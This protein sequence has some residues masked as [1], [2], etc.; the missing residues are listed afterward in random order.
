MTGHLSFPKTKAGDTPASLSSWFIHDIL[1]DK[2]NYQGLIITDDLMMNGAANFAGS[3]SRA[4]KQ[5]LIAG[6]DIIMLSKT[7]S[8][9]DQVWTYLLAAM[10]DEPDFRTRVRDAA[11][12]ILETKFEY[13]RGEKKV[14]YIPDLKKVEEG[15]PDPEGAAFFLDLAARSVTIIKGEEN[16]FPLDKE[17]A[18][19]VLLAG[20]YQDFFTA[21]K[22][23]YPDAISYWYSSRSSSELLS[24]ARN[25]DTIIFC[26]SDQEGLDVL[27]RLRSLGKKI[28][29]FSVLSPVYLDE[30][31]WAD[32]AVAVYSYA[33]ESFIAGFSAMLGRIN[34]GGQLPFPLNEPRWA[35]PGN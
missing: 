29:I 11:R 19:K 27:R 31:S 7:P 5:A 12:R 26:L 6:N 13:L 9:N 23:A 15:L 8:L 2:I 22:K 35:P 18:G 30:A 28:I 3:L 32:G 24:Y 33:N 1:R 21:G 14:A 16:I 10:K 34:A 20:Q 17:K 25:S 4:A